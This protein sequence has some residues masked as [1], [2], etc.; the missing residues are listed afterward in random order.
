MTISTTTRANYFQLGAGAMEILLQQ[1][2]YLREQFTVSETLSIS[3][4]ELVKLR[5]SQI[6]QC[7]FCIDMHSRDALAQGET[8]A[9][10][11]GLNAWRDMP[12]YTETERAAL[13]WAEH[14]SAALAVDDQRYRQLVEVL[15]E[16]ALVDLNVAINAI[17]SWNRIAK[18]FKPEVGSY[19]P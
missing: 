16:Q 9:R 15:G 17:N 11:L 5:V 6:N 12:L 3:L 4:W 14:L 19:K 18:T 1:E 7:A 8:T 2:N 13:D 10:L